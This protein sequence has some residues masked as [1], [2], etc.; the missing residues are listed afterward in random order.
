MTRCLSEPL[1]TIN[2]PRSP[3]VATQFNP[4]RST[5]QITS[6]STKLHTWQLLCSHWP[7]P[8]LEC[9]VWPHTKWG[10]APHFKEIFSPHWKYLHAD[11]QHALCSHRLMC[12]GT[13]LAHSHKAAQFQS[14]QMAEVE[15]MLAC[16][17]L[18]EKPS[19]AKS[20]QTGVRLV[21][22][23]MVAKLFHPSPVLARCP[24]CA[25]FGQT[26]AKCPGKLQF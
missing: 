26:F 6:P 3:A 8:D 15:L 16:Q 9:R 23:L 25:S 2:R 10:S 11:L 24:E 13:I 5:I 18:V 22:R 21:P 17:H 1:H 20:L 14:L 7:S 4:L 19:T 12:P